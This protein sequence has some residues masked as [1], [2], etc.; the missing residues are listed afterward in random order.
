MSKVLLFIA[1][2][3]SL[4]FSSCSKLE[5]LFHGA[6]KV[7][8][9]TEMDVDDLLALYLLAKTDKANLVG[10]TIGGFEQYNVQGSSDNVE[11][12]LC[13]AKRQ[14][15]PVSTLLSA[16]FCSK[17]VIPKDIV[18]LSKNFSKYNLSKC[19]SKALKI[20]GPQL[21]EKILATSSSKV[22]LLCLGPMN[23]IAHVLSEDPI[24]SKKIERIVML[25]GSL[26]ATENIAVPFIERW[27]ENSEFD[28]FID[29]CAANIVL[30]SGIPIT[31]VPLDLTNFIPLTPLVLQQYAPPSD[32]P[33]AK[34]VM[35]V[36]HDAILE[37]QQTTFSPF[38]DMIAIMCVTHPSMIRTNKVPLKIVT[39]EGP[40]FGN[41]VEDSSGTLVD[42]CSYIDAEKF[43]TTFF[44]MIG[45]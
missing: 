1:I 31:L 7:I 34:F 17:R 37:E 4:S 39:E 14:D 35:Q 6:P 5:H 25:G 22:T 24:A 32:T 18:D 10:V 19:Q 12:V 21:V 45:K 38:W 30:T 16:N 44:D 3:F 42:V 29:P 15:I 27:K 43:Y 41:I 20:S 40:S 8:F 2:A 23:N 36:L 13:L 33:G 11:T 26:H 28:F 9:D